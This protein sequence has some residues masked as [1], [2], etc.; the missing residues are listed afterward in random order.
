MF[1]KAYLQKNPVIIARQHPELRMTEWQCDACPAGVLA[2]SDHNTGLTNH[3][4]YLSPN[5]NAIPLNKEF[6]AVYGPHLTSTPLVL[7]KSALN[8]I[9]HFKHP[10]SIDSVYINKQKTW[11]DKILDNTLKNMIKLNLI[12]HTEHSEPEFI[13]STN[14]LT[15]LLH[16]TTSCNM[17]CDYCYLPNNHFEMP[18]STGYAIIDTIFRSA[19]LNNFQA[20]KLKYTGGEPLSCFS[21]ILILHEYATKLADKYKIELKG[22]ILS[23]GTLLTPEHI[24]KIKSLNLRLMISLDGIKEYHD[25]HRHFPDSSGSFEKVSKAIDL[26]ISKNLIPDIS[27]T[28]S[29]RNVE[30]LPQLLEWVLERDLPFSLNFYR[31]NDF[32]KNHKDLQLKE[33]KI[34]KG[35]LNA[36]K[37]IESHLPRQSLLASLA[38]RANLAIP[39]LRPCSAGYSYM[40]FDCHGKIFKCQMQMNRPVT[41]IHAQNPLAVIRQD[42]TGIRN[43]KVDEK[44]ECKSCQWKYWCAGG[45]PL[46][47]FR[48]TG[49]YDIKSRNC[50]IYKALFPE[51]VRLEG[52][53]LLKFH[54]PLKIY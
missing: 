23:N 54:H 14:T 37:I 30:G 35:M 38:D 48:A 53:R 13:E 19:T 42:K 43:I 46:S 33:E 44:Q 16:L 21:N 31:E 7:N 12:G 4:N 1:K 29:S 28:V 26:A 52:L 24:K 36:Y 18:L 6:K 5:L 27:I 51:I 39:H 15:S 3:N 40:V 25:C 2:K 10:K 11:N 17:A 50:S 34:I 8:L 45:C 47:A 49:R 41:D 32:S 20:I 9:Q 22:V